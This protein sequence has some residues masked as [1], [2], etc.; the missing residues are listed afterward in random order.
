MS[1]DS[2]AAAVAIRRSRPDDA[3]AYARLMSR[4][5]VFGNLLQL[6]YPSAEQW[7]E[8]LAK[9]PEGSLSLVA[10][11]QGDVVASGGLFPVTPS[12]AARRRH[13]LG[14]GLSVAQEAQ[15]RGVG[16]ALMRAMLDWADNWAQVL[17]IELHVFA[18]NAR[19]IALYERFGFVREGLH[20]AYA[21]RAGVYA[22]TLSMARLHPRQPLLPA[23]R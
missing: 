17:R 11:L 8:R 10:E 15:G 16:T 23:A 18:D 13:A 2:G 3:E 14:L 5:E 21:L 4:E 9:Q 1:A 7:R 6:P 22:D 20:R 19:A 12:F